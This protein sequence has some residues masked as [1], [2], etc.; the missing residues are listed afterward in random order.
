VSP[1]SQ[2]DSS[3]Y[4]QA[5]GAGTL[6][7][8]VAALLYSGRLDSSDEQMM[9]ATA[10]SIATSASLRF[11]EMYGQTFTGYG[12]G[13][14]LAGVPF[15]WLEALLGMGS[16]VPAL[17]LL[18]NAFLLGA[19][20][21]LV[22]LVVNRLGWRSTWV[23]W[24]AVAVTLGSPALPL[25]IR[26]YSDILAGCGLLA[27]AAGLLFNQQSRSKSGIA[28]SLLGPAF[29]LMAR[30]SVLPLLVLV[31]VWGYHSK[32]R[33]LNLIPSAIGVL[34]GLG[35][36]A[37]QNW[38]LRGD[39]FDN[40]YEGQEF[41]TPLAT[42]LHG[43]LFSPERGLLVF[44]PL[45]LFLIIPS[46]SESD[47]SRRWRLLSLGALLTSVALHG[48]FWTWHGGW[49]IGPRF[50]LPAV[51]LSFPAMIVT[52]RGLADSSPVSARVA[53][54]IVWLW[55]LTINLLHSVFHAADAYRLVWNFH[56][57]ESRWQFEPQLS[58]LRWW[59]V[60]AADGTWYPAVLRCL[61]AGEKLERDGAFTLG[62]GLPLLLAVSYLLS[63][64]SPSTHQTRQ[65]VD[66]FHFRSASWKWCGV[67]IGILA[68]VLVG[69]LR[70]ERGVVT[71]DGDHI[72]FVRLRQVPAGESATM[73]ALLDLAPHGEYKIHG[74]AQGA[75]Q[76][77]V[78]GVVV[79]E[80][81]DREAPR[82]LFEGRFAQSESGRRFLEVTLEAPE[83]DT[84]LI[85]LYWTWPGEGV[86]LEAI[87][88]EYVLP[89]NLTALESLAT[90]LWRQRWLAFTMG[91][92]V[93]VLLDF[94]SK[95]R[96]TP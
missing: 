35:V 52:L 83:D 32:D 54:L 67:G 34:I 74:R 28:L 50:L 73:E 20:V 16:G 82:H 29:A 56:G 55:G 33:V 25:A 78:D 94:R 57:L 53:M 36:R 75:W 59:E 89:R 70:G 61:L 85:E 77:R 60:L 6:V 76:V 68:L 88:G 84:G 45:V 5:L 1:H 40:G 41:T 79:A 66:L 11:P 38:S 30:P 91:V 13:T 47:I 46:K 21:A 64:S 62:L 2:S 58:L 18:A 37:L 7:A 14:P 93:L 12:L 3:G 24:V 26:Y 15:A 31:L 39:V 9:A 95:P 8:G 92:F 81:K 48:V 4:P 23:P 87:G 42:G 17:V 72:P 51:M 49:T 43:L 71:Q 65:I 86:V 63:H 69:A 10:R 19:A 27:M 96:R 44:W 80:G 22:V 90:R